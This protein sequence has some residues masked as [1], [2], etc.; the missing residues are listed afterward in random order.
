MIDRRRA[1]DRAEQLFRDGYNCCEGVATALAEAMGLACACLPGLATG[2]GGGVGHTGHVCGAVTGGAMA[3]GLLAVRKHLPDHVAEKLWAN[4][5]VTELIDA[6][7]REFD[8]VDCQDLI[9]M[10]WRAADWLE[11]YNA[12]GCKTSCTR[13]VRFAADWV[14]G[15]LGDEAP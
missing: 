2:M 9:G 14:A 5:I 1:A 13:F 10:D 11:Q 7:H 8:A 4:E 3:I 6:F 12:R 15:R